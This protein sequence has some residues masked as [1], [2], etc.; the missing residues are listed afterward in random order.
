MSVGGSAAHTAATN[1]LAKASL[2][3][4]AMLEAAPE[5]VAYAGGTFFVS[6]EPARRVGFASVAR[7]A[8]VANKLPPGM[9]AGLDE[10]VFYEPKGMNTPNGSH[11]AVVEVD[12]ETGDVRILDYVAVDDIG[13]LINPMLCHGQ[14]H[15]GLAQGIGQALFEGVEYDDA[16]QLPSG[17]LLDYAVPK[18]DQIPRMRTSFQVTPSPTNPLGVKGIG[19][20]GCVA[21]PPVIVGAVCDALRT[22]G[23]THIDM[24][25]TPP[26]VWRAIRDAHSA[27]SSNASGVLS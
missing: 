9:S 2:I 15:G 25:L 1:I 6:A 8:H 21:A 17:S 14:M 10:T 24:P 16:G 20:A 19:E 5:S 26:R 27:A 13:N 11:A 23:V 18:S 4:A 3:A 7:M 22:F 12:I